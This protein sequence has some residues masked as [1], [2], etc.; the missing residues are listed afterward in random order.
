MPSAIVLL[1]EGAEEMETVI[2]VDVL[3]RGGIDVTVAGLTGS[4]PVL[5]SRQVK[6][7]PDKS[8][9]DALKSAPYD[10]VVLPG[11]GTGAKNLCESAAVGK[12]LQEQEGR[13]ALVAAVCAAP[14]ALLAH[15]VGKGKSV[16]SHPGV[17]D[18]IKEGD[19]KYSEDRVVQDGKLITSRG[20]GTCFE[21]ALKIVE[22][23]QGAEKA[24]SL[25]APMLVKM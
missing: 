9:D 14:T 17:A 7:V 16:T 22:A 12:L 23:I 10:V 15:G 19:Y 8:L 6:V 2:T 5:C 13:D 18:K 4:D 21:F 24:S 25:V 1:A 11:G 20:P 3:R